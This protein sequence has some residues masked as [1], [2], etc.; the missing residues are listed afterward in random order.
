MNK[1][2]LQRKLSL[3]LALSMLAPT[4]T[5]LP[6]FAEVP[7]N[8]V[9]ANKEEGFSI[10]DKINKDLKGAIKSQIGIK[11]TDEITNKNILNLKE[12]YVGN[13]DFEN[14][15]GLEYAKNLRSLK[16]EHGTIKDLSALSNLPYFEELYVGGGGIV[17]GK[18]IIAVEKE[19]TLL[20]LKN[21]KKLTLGGSQIQNLEQLKDL[22]K[23]EYL[24]L[25][26]NH[27]KNLHGI[28]NFKN[29]KELIIDG[30]GLKNLNELKTFPISKNLEK[31]VILG[32]RDVN[33][34]DYSALQKLKNL[35]YFYI[36]YLNSDILKNLNGKSTIEHLYFNQYVLDESNKEKDIQ[37]FNETFK[38]FVNIKD[39][40]IYDMPY[41]DFGIVKNF[42]KLKKLTVNSSDIEDLTPIKNLIE[43]TQLDLSGN[44][45]IDLTPLTN[46]TNLQ[47]LNISSNNIEDLTPLQ[48]LYNLKSIDASYNKIKD[49]TPIENLKNIVELN[50]S[51]NPIEKITN[52]KSWPKL[53][54]LDISESKIQDLRFISKYI[55]GEW[56][57]FEDS[58]GGKYS[59]E[60][61]ININNNN[62]NYNMTKRN[63]EI[64]KADLPVTYY[65]KDKNGEKQQVIGDKFG[66]LIKDGILQLNNDYNVG[67]NIELEYVLT[68]TQKYDEYLDYQTGKMEPAGERPL[69]MELGTITIDTS[70]LKPAQALTYTPETTL[71]QVEKDSKK[72]DCNKG[73]INL[74]EG[75]EVTPLEG[76]TPDLT[77]VGKKT[78]KVKITLEDG[79]Y[80]DTEIPIEVKI[81]PTEITP[82]E[83]IEKENILPEII[84]V[85]DQIDLTDNIKNLPEGTTVKDITE[86]KIDTTKA[87]K[88][89]ATVEIT[90]KD[91]SGTTVEIPVEI[92]ELEANTYNPELTTPTIEV[93][94][95]EKVNLEDLIE[96]TPE[97]KEII[98]IKPIDTETEGIKEGLVKIIF[99]D[100]SEKEIPIKV[101]IKLKDK[102]P[103]NPVLPNNPETPANPETS[104]NPE[105]TTPIIPY[106]PI[107]DTFHYGEIKIIEHTDTQKPKEKE[108]SKQEVKDDKS[109][110]DKIK[111]DLKKEDK[112]ITKKNQI[113]FKIGETSYKKITAGKEEV[114]Q[115]DIAPFIDKDRTYLPIRNVAEAIGLEVSYDNNT[116]TATFKQNNDILQ[117]KIDT[118]K[119]TKNG[120]PYEME[121]TPLLENDR[122]VAPI[123]VIG[124]AFNKTVSTL[125][126]NKN[127]DI[128]WNQ[129]TQEVIIYNYK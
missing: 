71:L 107:E 91:G 98:E 20:K 82:I 116:R 111:A 72:V 6:V 51:D 36:S 30:R 22:T 75:A 105:I 89:T 50:I 123:S 93:K 3:V 44:K 41:M 110:L 128:V 48:S 29:L 102:L 108:T 77:K 65:L 21:L 66:F 14:L 115:M 9:E 19:E 34:E 28:E 1:N 79:S 62:L 33:I 117:I 39:L 43:L 54:K 74:P 118:K 126:E 88:Y 124:K 16:S 80:L 83:E 35:K 49:I 46:L 81:T 2:K 84:K 78:V 122:L 55:L 103:D 27:M 59:T 18:P 64:L 32:D 76:E 106:K 25:S 70:K 8:G 31:L 92:K 24:D 11:P 112:Q 38:K 47:Y 61:A 63:Q 121:V 85:G 45:I 67:D 96:K 125:K 99:N 68:T 127:T 114:K 109:E 94:Q 13:N 113:I 52:Q 15:N 5:T 42:T 60:R 100:G 56:Y 40:V 17:N 57:D 129:N 53:G 97:I 4:V 87:G 58:Y 26:Y 7:V 95:G 101:E 119:A 104:A 86:P 90:Y 37:I 12:L 120:K 10:E 23:L 73:I 69:E